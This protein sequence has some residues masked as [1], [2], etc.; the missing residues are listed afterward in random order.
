MKINNLL[1]A[2][3]ALAFS[4][5]FAVV[6]CVDV[7]Q[8]RMGSGGSSFYSQDVERI[9]GSLNIAAD[10]SGFF[11][12]GALDITEVQG[13]IIGCTSQEGETLASTEPT[14]NSDGSSTFTFTV[15]AGDSACFLALST[16]SVDGT[17]FS[18]ASSEESD[19]AVWAKGASVEATTDNGESTASI[20]ILD[21]IDDDVDPVTGGYSAGQS[22]TA[23]FTVITKTTGEDVTASFG[24]AASSGATGVNVPTFTI[25]ADTGGDAVDSFNLGRIR[26]DS[27]TDA[28]FYLLNLQLQCPAELVGT[29]GTTHLDR[30]R[31]CDSV[32]IK[33]AN[34]HNSA[35]AGAVGALL[36]R[37]SLQNRALYSSSATTSNL[38]MLS[39][40]ASKWVYL[41]E[42]ADS[43]A[44]GNPGYYK[45]DGSQGCTITANGTTTNYK[46]CMREKTSSEYGGF[47]LGIESSDFGP[48]DSGAP[49]LTLIVE[50][51]SLTQTNKDRITVTNPG[52][53]SETVT[54]NH[55]IAYYLVDIDIEVGDVN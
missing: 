40:T 35:T 7:V 41:N 23:S 34:N 9:P 54:A 17:A 27:N 38:N 46:A 8:E 28:A 29:G 33:A 5:V 48:A 39:K 16:I 50:L 1:K 43:G 49:Q 36:W 52:Q 42:A 11:L 31:S 2:L 4:V 53:P 15:Q 20:D 37:F 32:E 47:N 30:T 25:D 21:N 26:R 3:K 51:T 19:T 44:T 14:I 12:A 45:A 18:V 22:V 24:T 13:K 6:S 55:D 10:D